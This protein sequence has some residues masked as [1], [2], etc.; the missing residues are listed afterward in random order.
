MTMF[1]KTHPLFLSC[2]RAN[3]TSSPRPKLS[4]F[5]IIYRAQ[6]SEEQTALLSQI[7]SGMS[8]E[9]VKQLVEEYTAKKELAQGTVLQLLNSTIFS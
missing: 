3:G 6:F 9:Q 2:V 8:P 7:L 1:G 5:V 4:L